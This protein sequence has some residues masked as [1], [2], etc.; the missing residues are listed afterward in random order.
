MTMADADSSASNLPG[1]PAAGPAATEADLRPGAVV[2]VPAAAAGRRR[3]FCLRITEVISVSK[4]TGAVTL[5]GNVLGVDGTTS[6]RMPLPRTVVAQPARL[7]MVRPAGP[8]AAPV[9][10]DVQPSRTQVAVM[11]IPAG[12][13]V[14]LRCWDPGQDGWAVREQA[15][16]DHPMILEVPGDYERIGWHVRQARL[17]GLDRISHRTVGQHVWRD[18]ADRVECGGVVYVQLE[19]TRSRR[20]AWI[21]IGLIDGPAEPVAEAKTSETAGT[22]GCGWCGNR[23]MIPGRTVTDEQGRAYCDTQCRGL[24]DLWENPSLRLR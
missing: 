24:Q 1:A 13:T 7:I 22:E 2:F 16:L 4:A 17:A 10:V 6:R 8:V 3:P 18:A 23:L 11:V 20:P 15:D 19:Q 5:A 9:Y 12:I 14:R 21:A